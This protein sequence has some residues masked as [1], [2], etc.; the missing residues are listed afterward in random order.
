MKL[1]SSEYRQIIKLIEKAH[2]KR[3]YYQFSK[4][5]GWVTVLNLH[6]NTSISFIRKDKTVLN[7]AQK[8]EKISVYKMKIGVQTLDNLSKSAFINQCRVW[9]LS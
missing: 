1:L 6:E 8:F 9:L 4:K 5:R 2:K 3:E 7:E